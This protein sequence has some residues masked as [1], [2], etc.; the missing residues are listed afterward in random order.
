MKRFLLLIS[1]GFFLLG[2]AGTQHC[3]S[4]D[5]VYIITLPDG[6]ELA[7]IPKGFFDKKREGTDWIT[8]EAFQALMLKQKLKKQSDE[9]AK[10]IN[11]LLSI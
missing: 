6:Y 9:A 7:G 11:K 10:E 8:E 2:C 5:V 3:P 4:Q 1:I